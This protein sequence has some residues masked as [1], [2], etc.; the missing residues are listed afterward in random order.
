[1][2]RTELKRLA[3]LRNKTAL[4]QKPLQII[5]GTITKARKPLRQSRSTGK[6]TLAESAKI[7]AVKAMGCICCMLNEQ[8]G[9]KRAS[10]VSRPNAM[11]PC[12]AHHLLSGGIRRGHAFILGL[13]RWHHQGVPPQPGM[14]ERDAIAAYG[15]TVA[16]GSKPFHATYGTDDELLEFQHALLAQVQP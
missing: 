9:L 14:H 3:P 16:T 6:P 10:R 5:T 12:E 11:V 8:L 7:A 15:P 2:K 1:M 13:C 4:R